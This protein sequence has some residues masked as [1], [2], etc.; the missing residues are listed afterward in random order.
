MIGIGLSDHY[1]RDVG[2]CFRARDHS[3]TEIFHLIRAIYVRKIPIEKR[4]VESSFD[5]RNL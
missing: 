1:R 5:R 3:R 2:F 4:E